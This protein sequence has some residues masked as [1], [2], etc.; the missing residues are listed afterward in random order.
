M[1]HLIFK[2][3]SVNKKIEKEKLKGQKKALWN[4]I[5]FSSGGRG[6][7]GKVEPGTR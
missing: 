3:S 2:F 7:K 1:S 6:Y 5:F 4:K